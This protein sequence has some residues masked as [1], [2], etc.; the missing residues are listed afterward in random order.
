MKLGVRWW[1]EYVVC[2][3][4]N[5]ILHK[6][7]VGNY[8]T[9]LKLCARMDWIRPAHYRVQRGNI[10]KRAMKF[11]CQ[12]RKII[13]WIAYKFSISHILISL[14]WSPIQED[15]AFPS[16]VTRLGHTELPVDGNQQG[17]WTEFFKVLHIILRDQQNRDE[18]FKACQQLYVPTV[19]TFKKFNM[20]IILH[21][22]VLRSNSV[23]YL[24]QH[25]QPGFYKRGGE[26]LQRGTDWVLI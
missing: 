7:L 4:W 10:L 11:E 24:I 21:L 15:G 12:T 14:V 6:N 17:P 22:S 19:L 13:S 8:E 1:A 3:E 2:I 26:C 5:R 16:I 20:V 18:P 23:F 9:N 25:L